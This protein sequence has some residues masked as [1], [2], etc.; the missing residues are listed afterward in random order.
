M[1]WQ[2]EIDELERRLA[3]AR[4]MGGP[5]NVERQ[6]AG[7]KLTIR[8]RL[9]RLVDPGSVHETGALTGKA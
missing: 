4:E 2:P 1:S 7:G 9:E 8:E 3:L 6:H 5:A